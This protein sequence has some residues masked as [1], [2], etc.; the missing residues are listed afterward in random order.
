MPCDHSGACR[1]LLYHAVGSLPATDRLGLTVSTGTFR[2]QMT[3][4]KEQGYQTISLGALAKTPSERNSKRICITF[5]DG[6]ASQI[7][8]AQILSDLGFTAT[9]FVIGH[10]ATMSGNTRNYWENWPRLRWKEIRELRKAGFEIG[11]HSMTHPRLTLLSAHALPEET[12]G[13][14]SY[15]EDRLG[16]RISS[17]SYPYGAYNPG[18][19]QAVKNAGYDLACTSIYGANHPFSPAFELRRIE[20]PSTDTISDFQSKVEGRYDWVGRF[21]RW[22]GHYA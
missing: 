18:V 14:K 8:A 21:Q 3:L 13:A 10:S 17:Y 7:S 19:V 4:L 12:S 22:S 1:I 9:F 15:I 20:I 16:Y 2:S 5:D 11:A 6:Y